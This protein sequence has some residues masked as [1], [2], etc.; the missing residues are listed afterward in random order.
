MFREISKNCDKECRFTKG[1]SMTTMAYYPPVYDKNGVNVNPDG[2]T[3]TCTVTCSTCNKK[4][5]TST[6]YG[7]TTYEE[8]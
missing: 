3:T 6:R 1:L 2:N 7:E 5:T 4:W 8:V